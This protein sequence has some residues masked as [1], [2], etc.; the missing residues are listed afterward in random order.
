M[1]ACVV[2]ADL[3]EEVGDGQCCRS[4][5]GETTRLIST[6]GPLQ[7]TPSHDARVPPL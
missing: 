6:R 2:C 3:L 1:F 7:G 5:A 4:E